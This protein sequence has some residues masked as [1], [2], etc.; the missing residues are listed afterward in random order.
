MFYS[1][2]EQWEGQIAQIQ[3]LRPFEAFARLPSWRIQKARFSL[4]PLSPVSARERQFVEEEYLRRYF[5]I[6]E[7]EDKVEVDFL[8]F[9]YVRGLDAE[10]GYFSLAELES[11]RGP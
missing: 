3:R 1:P 2:Q 9:G 10:L 11:L 4:L 8:F 7:G 6:K 5:R